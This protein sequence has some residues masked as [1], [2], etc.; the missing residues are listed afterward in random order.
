MSDIGFQS[1]DMADAIK[2][3]T[4]VG[5]D[6]PKLVKS[7][8][9]QVGLI[10][11]RRAK[12]FAPISPKQ[13]QISA[14]LKTNPLTSIATNRRGGVSIIRTKK[15]TKQKR[16][17]GA[18]QRSIKLIRYTDEEIRLGIPANAPSSKYSDYIHNRR[19]KANGWVNL[20][21]GSKRKPQDARELFIPAAA[22][23]KD[24]DFLKKYKIVL[25]K[26]KRRLEQ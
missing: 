24:S 12:E 6:F 3:L 25:E 4:K 23:D 13:E 8:N 26:I 18:L 22:E 2:D 15:K 16:Q 14:A 19:Y 7:T 10:W 20:G 17:P 11:R 9:R 1:K 21:L 5:K